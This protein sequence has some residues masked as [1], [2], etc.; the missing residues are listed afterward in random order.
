MVIPRKV[1]GGDRR[2]GQGRVQ[3]GGCKCPGVAG[4]KL[5]LGSGQPSPWLSSCLPLLPTATLLPLPG[6]GGGGYRG[7][8]NEAIL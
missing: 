4:R 2:E 8:V 5:V 1:D 3:A 6:S 7:R